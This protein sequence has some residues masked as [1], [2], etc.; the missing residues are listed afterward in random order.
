MN[1]NDFL[2]LFHFPNSALGLRYRASKLPK[3]HYRDLLEVLAKG[4]DK[5]IVSTKQSRDIIK[6]ART[7]DIDAALSMLEKIVDEARK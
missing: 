3:G 2:W 5:R 1:K 7:G 4:L 6:K